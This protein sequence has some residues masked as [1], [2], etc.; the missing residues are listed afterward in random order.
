ML[1]SE[2][3]E[4]ARE[5]KAIQGLIADMD[6]ETKAEEQGSHLGRDTSV[7]GPALK[8]VLTPPHQGDLHRLM[9]V[10]RRGLF[11]IVESVREVRML[12]RAVVDADPA[13]SEVPAAERH[14]FGELPT[15]AETLSALMKTLEKLEDV[16][17]SG[18]QDL[19]RYP[20]SVA[21]EAPGVGSI[22]P[23]SAGHVDPL[24]GRGAVEVLLKNDAA[25]REASEVARTTANA[26]AHVLPVFTL[27]RI[28]DQCT[29]A[30]TLV[31][32]AMQESS[33][34][35]TWVARN[36][37]GQ[38]AIDAH[39]MQGVAP[40]YDGESSEAFVSHVSRIGECLAKV[41][42]A[43][44]L[45]AQALAP[46]Q[47]PEKLS[48]GVDLPPGEEAGGMDQAG[49]ASPLSATLSETHLLSFHE[50]RAMKLWRCKEA[51]SAVREAFRSWTEDDLT[52][53]EGLGEILAVCR[54]VTGLAE[55]VLCAGKAL[56]TGM[57]AFNKVRAPLHG[58]AYHPILDH[59]SGDAH[60]SWSVPRVLNAGFGD[61]SEM[62]M[63]R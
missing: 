17:V 23:T 37:A 9:Q 10:Q 50:G 47:G 35:Q 51:L 7:K 1:E 41:V 27:E 49:R 2:V 12:V 8:A 42:K 34:L 29:S 53:S 39:D 3:S 33:S 43:C 62:H 61:W 13:S 31:E 60:P 11:Q 15:D 16:V 52:R 32:S 40:D 19:E 28:A 46:K 59:T 21:R 63:Y 24:V 22:V 48:K 55:Q 5:M 36:F 18:L 26:F 38:K 20:W 45:S 30:V 58:R 25:L 57:I 14:E 54:D 4:L 6:H 44:L 56:L